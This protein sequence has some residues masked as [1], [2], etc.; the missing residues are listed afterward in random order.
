MK[1]E[2]KQNP[3]IATEY[4]SQGAQRI[5]QTDM[6]SPVVQLSPDSISI[7]IYGASVTGQ[8]LCEALMCK[9]CIT[10]LSPPWEVT[11]TLSI[12]QRACSSPCADGG[13]HPKSP[14]PQ[15][16]TLALTTARSQE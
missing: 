10:E 4:S 5:F 8:G 13:F 12:F 11:P 2:P 14:K 7:N 3:R 1:V 6:V 15:A 16:G 9:S